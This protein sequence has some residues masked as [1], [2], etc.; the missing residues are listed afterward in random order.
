MKTGDGFQQCYNA[1]VA[2]EGASRLIVATQVENGAA[3]D[4]CLVAMIASAGNNCGAGPE[5]V[6][7]HAGYRS[8]ASF[9]STGAGGDHGICSA[10]P[11]RQGRAQGVVEIRLARHGGHVRTLGGQTWPAVVS[12][13]KVS[14]GARVRMDQACAGVP[15]VEL[16]WLGSCA[17]RVAV[18]VR[19]LEPE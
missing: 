19:F 11:G 17:R 7:A 5:R 8:E 13:V 14:G 16:A 15:T 2:A 1:Q 18:V 12:E 4:C 10:L 3:D 9:L 6:P